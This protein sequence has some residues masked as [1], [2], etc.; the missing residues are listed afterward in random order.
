[1][2]ITVHYGKDRRQDVIIVNSS[3]M[4]LDAVKSR[5]TTLQGQ[6]ENIWKSGRASSF[7]ALAVFVFPL[8]LDNTLSGRLAG[9]IL[10][11]WVFILSE[12]IRYSVYRKNFILALFTLPNMYACKRA[13]SIELA[14]LQAPDNYIS[15]PSA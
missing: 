2:N 6:I 12:V 4:Q 7:V 5:V 11:A 14:R 1:M 13:W 8:Y 9:L 3:Y 15:R 10:A